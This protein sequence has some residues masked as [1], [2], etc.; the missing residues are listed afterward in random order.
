MAT[1]LMTA[2]NM[3]TQNKV[4]SILNKVYYHGSRGGLSGT[5]QPISRIR[6]D[7]GRGFYMGDTPIQ[8]KGLV[9]ED[10]AP[11]LYELIIRRDMSSSALTIKELSGTEWLYTV[12]ACR[13]RCTELLPYISHYKKALSDFD[14]V[15]GPI[16]DD[17]MNEAIYSFENGT[18]TDEGLMYCLSK[19]DYGQQFVAVSQRA[20]D[21]IQIIT[22]REIFG[23]EADQATEYCKEKRKESRGIVKEAQWLFRNKGKY[24][25][26]I[27]KEL[28]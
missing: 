10:S 23:Q 11:F 8:A 22:E 12:L 26:E 13:E 3:S 19:I 18:L 27:I 25:N 16:A 15:K 17:R 24:I 28:R 21:S 1:D 9:A 5:I 4:D 6:C 7:F 20:C 14:F 2:V